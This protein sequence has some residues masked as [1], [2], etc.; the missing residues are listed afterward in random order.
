MSR[1]GEGRNSTSRSPTPLHRKC[2]P[3]PGS[4]WATAVLEEKGGEPRGE[5]L[6]GHDSKSLFA[7]TSFSD[8]HTSI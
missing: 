7:T 6:E 5:G 4:G 2:T 1:A 8:L 3:V